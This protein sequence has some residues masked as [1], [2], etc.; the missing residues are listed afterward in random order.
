MPPSEREIL[1]W[2]SEGLPS[3]NLSVENAMCIL[4]SLA[5]P[6]L[7]DPST[8]ASE[9]LKVSL[10]TEEAPV[11]VTTQDDDRFV[12][13]L[14][15]AIRFGKTLLIREVNRIDPILYP[16]LRRDFAGTGPYK[17]VQVGEKA[18]DFNANFR[19]FMTTRNTN[20]DIPPDAR[21]AVST[22]NFT[23]TRAGLTGQLLAAA[24]QHDKP[25]LELRKSELLKKEEEHKIQISRLEDFLLEQG[26]NSID[27][28]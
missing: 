14:E 18:V 4:Q 17:V 1:L 24:L 16:V 26:G 15:L 2:R 28:L 19:L 27:I 22:V 9:W 6:F 3:D 12:L 7:V 25:E 23:T 10:G 13:T 21:A 20:P 8:R 11:E 5:S